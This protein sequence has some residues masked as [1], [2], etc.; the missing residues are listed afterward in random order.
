M[1]RRVAY[2]TRLN[3]RGRRHEVSLDEVERIVI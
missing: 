3:V 2:A 1:S